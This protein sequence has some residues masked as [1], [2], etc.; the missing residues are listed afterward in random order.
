MITLKSKHEI[1][2][3]R[4]AGHL[5]EQVMREL[6]ASCVPGIRTIELDRIAHDRIRKLGARPGF[7]GYNGFP[8]SICVS[9][10]DEAVHGIPGKRRIAEGDIVSLDLG[11]VL[12]G[13][14]ADMG[15]TVMVGRVSRQAEELVRVTR[16]SLELGIAQARVG[17][18]LFDISAAIQAHVEAAGFS[19]IRQFVGHGIGRQ[20]HE[21]PQL[22]NFGRPGTGPLL[23]A[24]MTLAIEPMVNAGGHEVVVDADGWTVRTKDGSLSA[25][26]EH[27]VAITEDG[28][29][30]LTRSEVAAI[31]N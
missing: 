25:Y 27:T 18:R 21:E 31:V 26:S 2:L 5:L 23:K 7:L 15:T 17:N 22:P 19:V 10:N 24:G 12:E 8:N 29:E 9:V 20:M 11:L 30:V 16:E 4:K 13:F 3:M 28:P 14:W 6:E 1:G